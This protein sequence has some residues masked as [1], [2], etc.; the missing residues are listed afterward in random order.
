SDLSQRARMPSVI[1]SPTPG[2]VTGTAGISMNS[3]LERE[4]HGR[5]DHVVGADQVREVRPDRRLDKLGLLAIVNSVRA[6]CRA[7]AGVAADVLEGCADQLLQPRR[8]ERP[9]PHVLRFLLD[10]HPLAS[11]TITSERG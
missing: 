3:L 4:V 1:D 8:R 11:R 5:I 10:P 6:R 2:T 7:R 9:A